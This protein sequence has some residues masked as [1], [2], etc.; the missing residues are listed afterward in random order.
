MCITTHMET[1]RTWG[2]CF[3]PTMRILWTKFRLSGF[4]VDWYLCLMS[5]LTSPGTM[6]LVLLVYFIC[7]CYCCCWNRV[8]PS[9]SGWPRTYYTVKA[10]FPSASQV[11]GIKAGPTVFYHTPPSHWVFWSVLFEIISNFQRSF[12]DSTETLHTHPLSTL[13]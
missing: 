13:C 11:L 6:F 12:Q 9:T 1:R 10:G 5:H 8:S 3:C 2:H 4:L 7:C